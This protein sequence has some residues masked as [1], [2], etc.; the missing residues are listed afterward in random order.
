MRIPT[1]RRVA[2]VAGL[3]LALAACSDP[4]PVPDPDPD[5]LPEP[6]ATALRDTIQAPIDKAKAVDAAEADKDA[7]R[8][9]TLEEIGD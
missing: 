8:R 6:Q 1:R 7:E 5:P 9:R 4:V 3:A 2:L